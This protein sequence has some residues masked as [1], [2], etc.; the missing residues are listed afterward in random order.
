[1]VGQRRGG[2]DDAFVLG[3]EG[4][5]LLLQHALLGAAHL[6]VVGPGG[7]VFHGRVAVGDDNVDRASRCG[8]PP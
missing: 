6:D 3:A 2:A 5:E 8:A 4:E 1:M 7:D